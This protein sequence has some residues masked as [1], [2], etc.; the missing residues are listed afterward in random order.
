METITKIN[1][2][3]LHIESSVITKVSKAEIEAR[4]AYLITEIQ[5]LDSLLSNFSTTEIKA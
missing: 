2:D 4:R 3:T 1:D 5:K